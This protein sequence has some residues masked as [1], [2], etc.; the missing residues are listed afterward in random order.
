MYIGDDVN[1]FDSL[2][3]AK[4]RITVP[5]A[6]QK[7]KEIKNIQITESEGGNGAFRE[8]VDAI[9]DFWYTKTIFMLK[10]KRTKSFINI[11]K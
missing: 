7:I 10:L 1:D 11:G 6:V 8:V 9:L 2:N 4:Y 5:N 3:F